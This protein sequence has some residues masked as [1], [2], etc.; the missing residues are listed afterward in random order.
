MKKL[1]VLA[2]IAWS[3]T[4]AAQTS[5]MKSTEKK[6]VINEATKVIDLDAVDN[7]PTYTNSGYTATYKG[8]SYPV[9]TSSK[10]KRFIFM[11]S[12]KSGK[13]YRKYID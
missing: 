4:M 3:M 11:I 8:T 2:A 13:Q 5:T 6:L 9:Y 10:G 12:K 7:T 1:I